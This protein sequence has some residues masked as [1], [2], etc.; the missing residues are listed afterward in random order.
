MPIYEYFCLDC[1][2]TFEL[3]RSLAEA[4]AGATC[5]SC[6]S[7]Q[8]RRLVSRFAAFSSEGGERRAVAGSSPCSGCN[9]SATECSSCSVK[10]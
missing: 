4:D 2:A 1:Q 10:R 9:L 6:G 7:S 8:T 3:M 5:E